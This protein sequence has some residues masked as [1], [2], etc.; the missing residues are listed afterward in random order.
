MWCRRCRRKRRGVGIGLW[1]TAW[2]RGDGNTASQQTGRSRPCWG[3][4]FTCACDRECLVMWMAQRVMW[5]ACPWPVRFETWGGS[6]TGARLTDGDA[7]ALQQR[8]MFVAAWAAGSPCDLCSG[9]HRSAP[10]DR[11]LMYVLIVER[12]DVPAAASAARRPVNGGY[13]K[14]RQSRLAAAIPVHGACTGGCC[15]CA[16]SVVSESRSHG[17]ACRQHQSAQLYQA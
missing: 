17:S 3:S 8:C 6:L 5:A 1:P 16:V 4:T 7:V 14:I 2:R 13:V 12:S 11:A 15:I 9:P 10:D